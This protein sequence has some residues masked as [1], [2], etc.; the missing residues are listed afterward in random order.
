MAPG[1]SGAGAPI[2]R[3]TAREALS[4]DLVAVYIVVGLLFAAG[5]AGSILPIIPGPPLIFAGTFL[6]AFATD[7]T[8][9][10]PGRLV[11]FA[12]LAVLAYL[13]GHLAGALGA[14]RFGGSGWAVAGALVGALVGV[15]W[16]PFGL[17]LGPVVGA[18]TGE[19]LHGGDVERSW[20]S[21]L[22]ALA[23]LAMGIIANLGLAVVMI[24]LFLWW[25][26]R[27]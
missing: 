18:I 16:G 10:G 6:Y 25:V 17:I 21:G 13:L 5:L 2:R 7:W 12:V 9:I 26:W 23:G 20:R 14:K 15:F 4:T 8:P 19:F 11:V 27:G 22:G 3:S 24:A 1:Q